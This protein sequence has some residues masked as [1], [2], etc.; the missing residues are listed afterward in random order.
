M[1][2]EER[3]NQLDLEANRMGYLSPRQIWLIRGRRLRLLANWFGFLVLSIVLSL[4]WLLF[5]APS[6]TLMA[7]ACDPTPTPADEFHVVAGTL[8]WLGTYLFGLVSIVRQ[9]RLLFWEPRSR[10]QTSTGP[11]VRPPTDEDGYPPAEVEVGEVSV[12]VALLDSIADLNEAA[13]YRVYWCRYRRAYRYVLS[14]ERA[15]AEDP[16]PVEDLAPQDKRM[17]FLRERAAQTQHWKD[18]G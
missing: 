18:G 13:L 16:A 12:P 15:S 17:A 2:S 9:V 14:M 4:C 5:L 3:L 1:Q 8:F 7:C 10:V 11:I 6:M